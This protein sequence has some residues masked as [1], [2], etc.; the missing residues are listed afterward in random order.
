MPPK[1]FFAA[2]VMEALKPDRLWTLPTHVVCNNAYKDDEEYF[3]ES[4]RLRVHNTWA[5]GALQIDFLDRVSKHDESKRLFGR[6]YREL[7]WEHFSTPSA[8]GSF[9][10]G[11]EHDEVRI[12]RLCWKIVRGLFFLENG[13]VLPAAAT[14]SFAS[15]GAADQ[16]SDDLATWWRGAAGKGRY[17]YPRV[18]EYRFKSTDVSDSGEEQWMLRMWEGLIWWTSFRVTNGPPS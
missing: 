13:I 12:T 3:V 16:A 4:M 6:T 14:L 10:I 7:R 1:Y 2:P 8:H 17:P 11:I 18:F 5:G 15:L 9:L